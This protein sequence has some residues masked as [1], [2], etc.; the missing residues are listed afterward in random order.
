[1]VSLRLSLGLNN[2][3]GPHKVLKLED[4]NNIEDINDFTYNTVQELQNYLQNNEVGQVRVMN[5]LHGFF[6]NLFNKNSG[7][8]NKYQHYPNVSNESS[9]KLGQNMD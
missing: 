9:V 7:M 6:A 2:Y 5:D 1:L 4:I 3:N 8:R